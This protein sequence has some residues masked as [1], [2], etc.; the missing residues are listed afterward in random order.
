MYEKRRIVIISAVVFLGGLAIWLGS[1]SLFSPPLS[2]EEKLHHIIASSPDCTAPCWKGITPGETTQSDL[3]TLVDAAP[4]Q[5]V[6]YSRSVYG[7]SN[8]VGR[9]E[10][11]GPPYGRPH[12]TYSWD[13][14]DTD[15]RVHVHYLVG[16]AEDTVAYILFSQLQGVQL[17]NVLVEDI[18]TI[19]GS[20]DAYEAA[21]PEAYGFSLS[22]RLFYERKGIVVEFITAD[23]PPGPHPWTTCQVTLEPDMPIRFLT[24]AKPDSAFS[25]LETI[26]QFFNPDIQVTEAW[27]DSN[28]L[29]LEPCGTFK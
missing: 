10:W 2:T 6:D 13:D 15:T 4:E 24:L 25:T 9:L 17:E 20:P 5:F 3:R 28:V 14:L 7:S 18:L 21:A 11:K 12:I 27:P 23:P 1:S 26:D 22:I 19:L 29:K 8:T 16:G